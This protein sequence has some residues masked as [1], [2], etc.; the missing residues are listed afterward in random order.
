MA[1]LPKIYWDGHRFTIQGNTQ[2]CT[3]AYLAQQI[4]S[5]Y[6]H[7]KASLLSPPLNFLSSFL[8][9]TLSNFP[10]SFLHPVLP[11]L[12]VPFPFF[13]LVSSQDPPLPLSISLCHSPHL[14]PK[15][16]FWVGY[17]R[18]NAGLDS[19]AGFYKIT[20]FNYFFLVSIYTGL[21][22]ALLLV[23]SHSQKLT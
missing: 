1:I 3:K 14:I 20:S 5:P 13:N 23:T 4:T 2:A 9:H 10:V 22:S 7:W 18:V 11:N 17:R 21:H 15:L 19:E 8:S 12:L 16:S 6:S